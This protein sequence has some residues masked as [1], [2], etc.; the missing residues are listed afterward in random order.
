MGS[1]KPLSQKAFVA[2]RLL[3]PESMW[4]VTEIP[5][6]SSSSPCVAGRGPAGKWSLPLPPLTTANAGPPGRTSMSVC[7]FRPRQGP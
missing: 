7:H 5:S 2:R 6:A 3:A 4:P 1:T